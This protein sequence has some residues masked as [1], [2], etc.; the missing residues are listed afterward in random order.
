MP[1]A[2]VAAVVVAHL[3]N[4][5]GLDATERSFQPL[6]FKH[7][8]FLGV[9]FVFLHHQEVQFVRARSELFAHLQLH[10][11]RV[12]RAPVQRQYVRFVAVVDH[13][14]FFRAPVEAGVPAVVDAGHA[15]VAVVFVR[16]VAA[17]H[18]PALDVFLV[19]G[20]QD[21]REA[22]RALAVAADRPAVAF[23]LQFDLQ[24]A[25]DLAVAEDGVPGAVRP[26]LGPAGAAPAKCQQAGEQG[27]EPSGHAGGRRVA[28]GKV[29]QAFL[30]PR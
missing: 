22:V 2:R 24:L 4:R 14:D 9:D 16:H 19:A 8:E 30:H 15:G 7:A 26:G 11:Q 1:G 23:A 28:A 17:V 29:N 27:A 3:F 6:G 18:D 5:D 20:A 12:E 13:G 21:P 25:G 10:G